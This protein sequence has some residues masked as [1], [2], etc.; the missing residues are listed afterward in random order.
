MN[1]IFVRTFTDAD[2]C[3]IAVLCLFLGFVL[4]RIA[5]ADLGS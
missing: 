5:E 3:I 1:C 2:T 4:G